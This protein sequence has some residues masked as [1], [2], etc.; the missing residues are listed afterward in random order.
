M[1]FKNMHRFWTNTIGFMLILVFIGLAVNLCRIQ[2]L[3][4]D[5]YLKLAKAQQSKKVALSARR[6]L[7]LDRNGRKLAESLRVGSVYANPSA[8]KDVS[9]VASHLSK[10]LHL[11]PSKVS[12]KLE[13]DKKF[14]WIKRRVSDEELKEIRKL[15][16]QGVYIEHEYQ[17]F[18]QNGPLGS[19]VIGF[20]DIDENGLEGIELSCN[21]ALQGEPG[22][23]RMYRDA[24]QS[25]ILTADTEM[26]RPRHGNNVMLTIDANI[27]RFAE[28]ELENLDKTWSPAS[29]TAIV[30]DISTGEILAMANLPAY[31]LNN[32]GKYPA[33]ARK[34]LA[35]T[36]YYEPGSIIKPIVLA[37]IFENKLARPNDMINCENGRYVMGKRILHDSH[38]YDTLTV[39]EIVTHSSNIGMAKLGM[40][41]GIERMYRHL[42]QF[43]FGNKSGIELSGEQGGIFRPMKSWSKQFSLVSVSIGHEIAATPLQFVTIF[44]SI[45]NGGLLLKP[46]IIKSITGNDG[47]VKEEYPVPQVVRRV[48]SEEVARDLLNPIL[49]DVVRNGTGKRAFLAEYEVAGKTGTSQ[50]VN[51]SDGRY[52]RNK[53]IA[54]FV[55]YAP[56]DN[57]RICVLIM[58]DEPKGAYYGGTVAAP[59]VREIIKKTLQYLE[60]EPLK[61]KM[62]MH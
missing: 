43:N 56:A 23:K 18:Y 12:A 57:P 62:A 1:Y 37:G 60:V 32:V 28:E 42:E 27:Q 5:K 51:K 13:K 54:S 50:K 38:R 53:Y 61:L 14:V 30:M 35:V 55:A 22:Y 49:V 46:V 52:S 11:N 31:D 39:A 36:D 21:Q 6:G 15:S 24:Q 17:R 48:M 59:S 10:V 25:N 41:M 2:V 16:L 8:I 47:K 3:E 9:L 4:H 19:H 34:N 29:A 20:T 33:R 40:R 7:I 26:R 45:A 58:A 44:S